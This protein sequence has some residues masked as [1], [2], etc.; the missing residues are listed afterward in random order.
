MRIVYAGTPEFAVPPLRALAASGH[1][2]VA[3]YSQ[4]DRP[5]GR[6]RK[7]T[8]GPVKAL[9]LE[10]RF[11]V[12]QPVSLKKPEE[13]ARLAALA[14]DL[15]VVAAYGLI[16]PAAVLKIPRLGCINIHAS[17]LPRW[18]GAAPIAYAILAGDSVTGI[19]I[20]QMDRGLDTGDMLLQLRSPIHPDDSARSLHD[21]LSAL[22]AQ[23]LVQTLPALEGGTLWPRPQDEGQATYAAKLDKGAAVLDWDRP[24]AELERRVRAFDPWPVA[25][26]T[27]GDEPLRVWRAAVVAATPGAV[28]GT[29][30]AA[31]R[32]GIDVACREATLRLLTVQRPGGRPI[33]AADYLHAHPLPPGTRLGR[34][35]ADGH[36]TRR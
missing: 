24:A 5:A 36:G 27:A 9:A 2:L 18:R 23:A 30:L 20:M 15:M 14:P 13:H 11:P 6:G 16:L 28:P 1:E 33:A 29:V 3:V 8:A 35:P 19:T 25:C 34:P 21:R 31:G 17:L 26:T 12:Y 10:H 22:G 32:E 7:L 4:P